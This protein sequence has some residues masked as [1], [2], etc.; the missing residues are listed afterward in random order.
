[1]E[2]NGGSDRKCYIRHEGGGT[3]LGVDLGSWQPVGWQMGQVKFD[4]KAMGNNRHLSVKG[5]HLCTAA[6]VSL[7]R[8]CFLRPFPS[9]F[10][11][12][13][14]RCIYSMQLVM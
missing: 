9:M 2:I 6:K 1:M 4:R 13:S 3:V 5:I 7:H 8:R 10:H 11:S 14:Y 12:A